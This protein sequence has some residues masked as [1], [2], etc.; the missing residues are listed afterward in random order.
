MTDASEPPAAAAAPI[1][2]PPSSPPPGG[3]FTPG[4]SP[5]SDE[6]QMPL[7]VYIL[8]LAGFATGG[9]TNVVGVVLAYIGRDSAPGWLRTH[10]TYQIRTFWIGLLY[11]AIAI[12]LCFVLIGVPLAAAATIWFIVR[13]A[14]GLSRLLRGEPI[15]NPETWMI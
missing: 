14:V 15:A 2:P 4:A 9:V 3:N 1:L 13:C 12:P 8:H 10:Y 7:I 5:F 6:R 11:F